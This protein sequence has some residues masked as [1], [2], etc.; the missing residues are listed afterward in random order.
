MSAKQDSSKRVKEMKG[1]EVAS[2][3]PQPPPQ[4]QHTVE[5]SDP[6]AFMQKGCMAIFGAALI[7]ALLWWA[8]LYLGIPLGVIGC[9][10]T[11]YLLRMSP[12]SSDLLD[13]PKATQNYRNAIILAGASAVLIVASLLGNY[14]DNNGPLHK[15][16]HEP[17]LPEKH[18]FNRN[19]VGI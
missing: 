15:W 14:F 16:M 6:P 2:R 13:Q 7:L 8:L 12:E 1:G 19:G 17:M 18:S 5:Y 10:I 4:S 3:S 9:G 11:V